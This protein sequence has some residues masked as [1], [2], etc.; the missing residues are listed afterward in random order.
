MSIPVL[1]TLNRIAYSKVY[2]L[3]S[4]G[5]D[6]NRLGTT[7]LIPKPNPITGPAGDLA[8]DAPRTMPSELIA[9]DLR[10]TVEMVDSVLFRTHG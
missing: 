8:Y 3:H 1:K 10:V 4:R 9:R 7:R 5:H 6:E 2:Q